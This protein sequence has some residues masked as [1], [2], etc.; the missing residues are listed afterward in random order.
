M[1]G[2]YGKTLICNT[3]VVLIESVSLGRALGGGGTVH[4]F[5]YFW[6]RQRNYSERARTTVEQLWKKL[7][8]PMAHLQ[9][10]Y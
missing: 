3:L 9:I 2:A 7:R 8:I 4:Y 1:G 5:T 10:N 6:I